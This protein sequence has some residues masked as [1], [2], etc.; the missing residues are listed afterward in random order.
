MVFGANELGIHGAG[1]ALHALKQYGAIL[2]QGFGPQ[3][4]SFG[5]P[6]CHVP[7]G[8]PGW[9]IPLDKV[10]YYNNCFLAWASFN[11]DEEFQVTQ[12]GCGFAGWTKEQIAP[13]YMNAPDNC[14]FDTAWRDILGTIT[15][16]GTE[17]KYW[18]TY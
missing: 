9:Q 10:V 2:H 15:P 4:N 5:I 1:A 12:I 7:V 6:T 18:G 14:Y 16:R 17:R 8:R 13:I 11:P 3:D